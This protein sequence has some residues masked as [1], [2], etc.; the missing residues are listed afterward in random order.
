M[1]SFNPGTLTPGQLAALRQA[2]RAGASLAAATISRMTGWPLDLSVPGVHAIP[3]DEVSRLIGDAQT[4]MVGL[5]LRI[6]GQA[7]GD[8]LIALSPATAH[9]ILGALLPDLPARKSLERMSEMEK[10]ALRE[11][12]NILGAAYLG[13]IGS[14][15]G[16]PLRPSAP[17]LAIDMAG[18][19]L[20]DL[21]AQTARGAE[22]ALI[23]E[24]EMSAQGRQAAGHILH[25]PDPASLPGMLAALESRSA[26]EPP[27]ESTGA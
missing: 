27:T 5:H 4:E 8:I 25:L 13:A 21:L 7:R 22:S 24:I 19:L 10:S 3:L 12:G 9:R 15:M 17:E 26:T 6:D 2:S 11:V 23:I 16:R 1:R 14:R 20:D 18:A